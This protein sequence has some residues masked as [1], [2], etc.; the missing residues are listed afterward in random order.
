ML[1]A[2]E[3]PQLSARS[4][5]LT[6][7]S[8]SRPNT[9]SSLHGT[10]ALR[11]IGDPLHLPADRSTPRTAKPL[12][13]TPNLPAP[14]PVIIVT[15]KNTVR[16]ISLLEP[17]REVVC[18]ETLSSA[19]LTAGIVTAVSRAPRLTK[20]TSASAMLNLPLDFCRGYIPTLV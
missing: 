19:A 17:R 4:L 12:H 20:T 3:H 7:S 9:S 6:D 14:N 11:T 16:N 15:E 18:T 1:V 8:S 2:A 5:A 13:S 10:L